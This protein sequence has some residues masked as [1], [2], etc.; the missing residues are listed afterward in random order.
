M[1]GHALTLAWLL[2]I[3]LTLRGVVT[4]ADL[5]AGILIITWLLAFFRPAKR[6]LH[7]GR[8]RPLA[9]L[10]TLLWFGWKL[11]EAN[12]HVALAVLAPARIRN[13]RAIIAVPVAPM[14]ETVSMLL[15]NAISLT[16]GTFIVDFRPSPPTMY[17]H[18]LQLTEVKQ[19]RLRFLELQRRIVRAVG[20]ADGV[21]RVDALIAKVAA[22]DEDEG[23]AG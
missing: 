6:Q 21:A 16:P 4:W 2:F 23:S 5:M 7:S 12:V 11:V 22:E 8:V 14:S 13:T 20:S 17:I 15:A 18:V 1:I 10:G 19:A 3:W 9:L